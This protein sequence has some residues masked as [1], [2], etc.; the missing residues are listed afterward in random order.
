MAEPIKPEDTAAT[1]PLPPDFYKLYGPS[2]Q[3]PPPPLPPQGPFQVFDR[4]FDLQEP[5]VTTSANSMIEAGPDGQIDIKAQLLSLN[6]ELLPLFLEVLRALGSRSA[7]QA[8]QLSRLML[9]L[10][11]MQHLTNM[12]RPHQAL[13]TLEYALKVEVQEREEALAQVRA[14]VN[15]VGDTDMEEF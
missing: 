9:V 8:A 2:Q 11:A 6:A 15:A 12:L 14:Q 3:G 7:V 1:F 4:Q 13:A 5:L 10:N